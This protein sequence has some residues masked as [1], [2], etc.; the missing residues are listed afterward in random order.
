MSESPEPT[1]SPTDSAVARIAAAIEQIRALKENPAPSLSETVKA[2]DPHVS[3]IRGVI[4]EEISPVI[5]AHKG[6]RVGNLEAK[7]IATRLVNELLD[8]IGCRFQCP[9]TGEPARLISRTMHMSQGGF[10]F[11]VPSR[12]TASLNSATFP[13]GEI[14]VL[15]PNFKFNSRAR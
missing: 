12:T 8:N 11:E 7:K 2:L 13:G 10:G 1:N 6:D 9:R 15:P 5:N 3:V 4:A 14:T